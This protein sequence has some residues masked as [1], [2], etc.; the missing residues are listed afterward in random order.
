[1]PVINALAAGSIT[2]KGWAL[3]QYYADRDGIPYYYLI[4]KGG[5]QP[6]ILKENPGPPPSDD[7]YFHKLGNRWFRLRMFYPRMRTAE[8][9]RPREKA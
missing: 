9:P 1:M 5:Q 4:R 6:E 2:Q 3:C 7:P 8:L